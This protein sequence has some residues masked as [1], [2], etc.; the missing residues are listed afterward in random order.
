MILDGD[1]CHEPP[2]PPQQHGIPAGSGNTSVRAYYEDTTSCTKWGNF[3]ICCREAC[4]QA[5]PWEG[6]SRHPLEHVRTSPET[7]GP[8]PEHAPVQVSR[9][10]DGELGEL[11]SE[12]RVDSVLCCRVC[13]GRNGMS[14][15]TWYRGG[16]A[17]GNDLPL[18]ICENIHWHD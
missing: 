7:A 1:G 13:L 4:L 18:R 9:D 2:Q 11:A 3:V 12:S 15:L 8:G 10:S 14:C 6:P 16:R 17:D 5:S